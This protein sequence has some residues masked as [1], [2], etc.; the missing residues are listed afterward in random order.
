MMHDVYSHNT[1]QYYLRHVYQTNVD[2]IILSRAINTHLLHV[3]VP[4]MLLPWLPVSER[5]NG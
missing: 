5:T 2:T 1:T 4:R 3:A